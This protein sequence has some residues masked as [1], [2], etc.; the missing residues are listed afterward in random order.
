MRSMVTLVGVL[1]PVA[2][3]NAMYIVLKGSCQVFHKPRRMDRRTR[4]KRKGASGLAGSLGDSDFDSAGD[5]PVPGH[6]ADLGAILQRGQS[7]PMR[8]AISESTKVGCPPA[9][10]AVPSNHASSPAPTAVASRTCEP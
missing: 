1:V 5:S 3:T 8:M 6:D 2:D 9:F 4:S 10:G 7:P